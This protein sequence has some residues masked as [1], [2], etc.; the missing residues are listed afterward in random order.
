MGQIFIFYTLRNFD[1]LT[2]STVTTT[3]KFFTI[4]VNVIVLPAANKLNN[5]QWFWVFVVFVAVGV[6][7][8]YS[9]GSKGKGHGGGGGGGDSVPAA[10]TPAA[11]AD[12]AP[13]SKTRSGRVRGG[14]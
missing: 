4:L 7:S 2:L 8:M 11:V 14:A 9:Q 6:D 13:A 5:T 10:A 12:A 1:S 3:R